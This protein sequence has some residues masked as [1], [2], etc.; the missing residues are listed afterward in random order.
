M[1]IGGTDAS[2]VQLQQSAENYTLTPSGIA[3]AGGALT[4]D[5]SFAAAPESLDVTIGNVNPTTWAPVWS[6]TQSLARAKCADTGTVTWAPV[7]PSGRKCTM[8]FAFENL[9]NATQVLPTGAVYLVNGVFTNTVNA[10]AKSNYVSIL[11]DSVTYQI[12]VTTNTI[13]TWGT[14]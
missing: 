14:P 13:G 3:A 8:W 6:P 10:F 12:Q 4:S 11:H 1:G 2:F 7:F 5:V 9:S